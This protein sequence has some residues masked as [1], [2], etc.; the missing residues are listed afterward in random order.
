TAG[1]NIN[2]QTYGNNQNFFTW[3]NGGYFSP[4]TFLSL[5]FPVNYTYESPRLDVKG[6]FTPGFQSFSQDRANLYPT[7]DAAQAQLD[8]LKTQN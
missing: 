3:G 7:D 2:Y 4:Q 6:S 1:L 8:A 5:G